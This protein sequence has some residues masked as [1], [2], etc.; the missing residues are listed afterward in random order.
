LLRLPIIWV[1]APKLSDSEILMVEADLIEALNPSANLMRP[2]PARIVQG[3]ATVVF[4]QLREII[5]K[6][7]PEK[8][9]QLHRSV[10]ARFRLTVEPLA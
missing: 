8:P 2:T 9:S 5:H 3:H 10:D 4:A 1:P 6:N 7:R